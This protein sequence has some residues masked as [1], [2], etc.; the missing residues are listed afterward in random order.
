RYLA[1]NLHP[2]GTFRYEIDART[3][4]DIPGYNWPRHGGATLFLAETAGLTRAPDLIDAARRACR[5]LAEQTT[6][7]CG[8]HRCIGEDDRVDLGSSALALLAY[9]AMVKGHVDD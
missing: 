6:L 2:D 1:R 9:A 7:R 5:R 4:T 3:N 8:A